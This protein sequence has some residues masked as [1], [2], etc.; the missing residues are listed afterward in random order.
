MKAF[1]A[2][3]AKEKERIIQERKQIIQ[4]TETH[5][6]KE[7]KEVTESER[8]AELAEEVKEAR[9]EQ[10]AVQRRPVF[11]SRARFLKASMDRP[12]AE[13]LTAGGVSIQLREFM[14]EIKSRF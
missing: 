6:K 11:R 9:D 12:L 1:D 8:N 5:A 4:D 13:D 7:V 3:K 14:A 2:W 10:E